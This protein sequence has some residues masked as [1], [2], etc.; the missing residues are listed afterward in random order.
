MKTMTY[1]KTFRVITKR[2]IVICLLLILYLTPPLFCDT[3]VVT[4]GM[5]NIS[6]FSPDDTGN[7]WGYRL[8]LSTSSECLFSQYYEGI[9]PPSNLKFR[10]DESC[11]IDI[12]VYSVGFGTEL[13]GRVTGII[14][15]ILPDIPAPLDL[16]VQ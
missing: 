2:G 4:D 12:S 10:L 6:W 3:F 11:D 5:I 9:T 13:G 7:L 1:Y 8:D 15:Y 16:S 14:H